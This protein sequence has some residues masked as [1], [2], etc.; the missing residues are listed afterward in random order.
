MRRFFNLGLVAF[1]L[2][3]A[4]CGVIE[5]IPPSIGSPYY[6]GY[7]MIDGL[8]TMDFQ[9]QGLTFYI[10]EYGN[11]Y[12]RQG[13]V[14]FNLQSKNIQQMPYSRAHIERDSKGRITRIGNTNI[15]YRWDDVDKIGGLKIDY[16]FGEVRKINEVRL[17]YRFGKIS[18]VG[19]LRVDYSFD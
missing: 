2:L 10:N 17:N 3:N 9:A 15:D 7:L 16:T 18:E 12:Y 8:R 5:Y 6:R 19:G 11:L 14:L 13:D 1:L 4:S